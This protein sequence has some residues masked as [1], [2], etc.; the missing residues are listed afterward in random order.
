MTYPSLGYLYAMSRETPEHN[1]TRHFQMPIKYLL[2]ISSARRGLAYLT[3]LVLVG[4]KASP[5]LHE[6]IVRRSQTQL[7]SIERFDLRMKVHFN[8]VQHFL[9]Y[10]YPKT[11]VEVMVLTW[12]EP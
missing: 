11:R 6:L 3:M 8:S 9:C 4:E 10:R 1:E 5:Q 12:P 7:I 2:F